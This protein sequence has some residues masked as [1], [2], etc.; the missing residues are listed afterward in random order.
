MKKKLPVLLSEK[1]SNKKLGKKIAA[2]YASVEATCPSTC[3]LKNNGC[4]AQLGFVGI[5]NSRLTKAAKKGRYNSLEISKMEA[6]LIDE[7]FKGGAVPGTSLRLHVS[8]DVRTQ[9]GVRHLAAAAR[10]FKARGGNKVWTY[11]HAWKKL[12][13]PLWDGISVLASV[14]STKEAAE[15]LAAGYAPAFVVSEFESEKAYMVDGI[16][17]I[18]CPEQT[19]GVPCEDCG[20]CMNADLLAKNQ[21]MILF[22]IH[23][24][25]KD[26]FKLNVV[27]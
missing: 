13:K 20:L 1:S 8:G 16:K 24:A 2:T 5:Y 19:R 4:Y 21:S 12:P 10:R 26:K 6:K 15:A 23:G 7:S 27:R 9:N 22:A 18:P 14:D 25:R 17:G 3:K 11:S